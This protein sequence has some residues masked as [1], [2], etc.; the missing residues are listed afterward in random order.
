MKCFSSLI[1]LGLLLIACD[2]QPN[3]VPA[4]DSTT[5]IKKSVPGFKK[6]NSF[7]HIFS[8]DIKEDTFRLTIFGDSLLT[9]TITFE[10]I[11]YTGARIYLDTFPSN[12]LLGYE[13]EITDPAAVKKAFMIKRINEFF[14]PD[15]FMSPAIE[16]TRT[17]DSDYVMLKKE[18]WDEIKSDNKR[19]GFS[20]LIGEENNR[21]I[22]Y[23]KVLRKVVVYF[24]CC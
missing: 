7:S 20:Y 21:D 19:T 13:V 23:S 2:T 9:A 5:V 12:Y 15:R 10:V 18:V 11:D 3:P 22:A 8:D 17:M 14:A 1:T 6:V 24:S 16:K 4:K